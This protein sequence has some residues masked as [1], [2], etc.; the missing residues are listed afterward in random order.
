MLRV[1]M[2]PWTLRVLAAECVYPGAERLKMHSHAEHGNDK[3]VLI[4]QVGK[5]RQKCHGSPPF[6]FDPLHLFF[7]NPFACRLK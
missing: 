6:H 4:F 2:T 3:N 5:E 1:G 7:G